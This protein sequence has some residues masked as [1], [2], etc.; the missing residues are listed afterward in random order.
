MARATIG[1]L[2]VKMRAQILQRQTLAGVLSASALEHIQDFWFIIGDD[3]SD[4]YRLSDAFQVIGTTPLASTAPPNSARTSKAAKLDLEAMTMVEWRGRRE[5]LAFGSG[6]KTPTRDFC[7]RIDVTEA[8]APRLLA[9]I[10]LTK[11]YEV[12]RATPEFVGT[13]QLNLEAAAAT[14]NEL[15]LFQR[16][17]ISG[18][19]A[20]AAF[21]FEAFMS[22]LDEPRSVVPE[23]HVTR[24]S[25]PVLQ[26]R[27][28]GFSAA[29]IL[30]DSQ[31]LFTASVEDTDNEIDDGTTLGS[32]IG[33]IVQG[34][35]D[36]IAIVEQDGEPAS[37][38]IEGVSVL[39]ATEDSVQC[40]AVTDNDGAASEV[41]RIDCLNH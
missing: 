20:I 15:L 19:N 26:N 3:A 6:S 41:L 27:N 28:A 8:S 21:D 34:Q 16:G 4:L 39:H 37:V 40:I 22:Y 29:A 10:P 25:L 9:Q 7:F 2:Q 18:N 35:L 31:I 24:F 17:N 23:P 12:L 30:N 5:L 11:L 14:T 32:F 13:Q 1:D 36:W 38:K 33:R